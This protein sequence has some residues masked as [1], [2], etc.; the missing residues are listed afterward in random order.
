MEGLDDTVQPL[1]VEFDIPG[2]PQQQGSKRHVGNGI[3]VEDNKNL[4]PWRMDAI[5]SARAAHQG[6]PLDGALAVT[7][8]F[9]YPRPKSHYRT[10]KNAHLLRDDAPDFKISAPDTDK[11]ERALGDALT[12]SGII[13]DDARIAVWHAQKIYGDR[14]ETLVTITEATHG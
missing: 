6:A 12:Q 2:I 7:V 8:D 14:P 11:L 1:R 3:S 5:A 10:G 4:K 9:I 13:R